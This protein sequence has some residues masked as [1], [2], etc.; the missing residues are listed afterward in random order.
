MSKMIL[1]EIARL[2]RM[3]VLAEQIAR[4]EPQPDPL[5]E[6]L[7]QLEAAKLQKEVE[8]LDSEID[9]NRAKTLEAE[10]KAAQTSIDAENEASGLTHTRELEKQTAQAEGNQ[11]L[12]VTKGLMAPKKEGEGQP[13]IEAAIGFNELSK[14]ARNPATSPATLNI[15]SKEFNPAFDPALNLGL[16]L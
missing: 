3:P 16:N 12:Q 9:L 7:K 13:D 11:D 5:Q 14:G 6:Q 8:K 4:Y 15:G 2:K 10:A 1:S